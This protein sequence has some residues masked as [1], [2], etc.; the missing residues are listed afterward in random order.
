MKSGIYIIINVVNNKVY[1]GK[2]LN[3]SLR[4]SAHFS[5]LRR[6]KHPNIY[7]QTSYNKHGKENFIF[8]NI[9]MCEFSVLNKREEFWIK[10]FCSDNREYGYNLITCVDGI[11]VYSK[12]SREKMSKNHANFAK[13]KHPFY[14][15]T[16]SEEARKKISEAAKG[17]TSPMKG[18]QCSKESKQKMSDAK[19]GKSPWNKG[20]NGVQSGEKHPL[21][22][23][24]N[25]IVAQIREEYKNN[26]ISQKELGEKY[27]ISQ[28]VISSIIHF[29][30][31]K[32]V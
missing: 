7:L 26:N 1:V 2:S 9:E 8:N 14:G 24:T 16:H 22:K 4:K 23:L 3:I 17:R 30:T 21:A 27:N 25:I 12:E 32:N 13:E 20:L 11:Q 6:Q 19:K 18:K 31:W 10:F 5:L 28:S 15:K 29:K